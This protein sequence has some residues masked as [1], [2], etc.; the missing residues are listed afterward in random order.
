M[1]LLNN[2]A[3][4]VATIG[5]AASLGLGTLIPSLST[6]RVLATDTPAATA[7]MLA[8]GAALTGAG[9]ATADVDAAIAGLDADTEACSALAS[10]E[11]AL[12]SASETRRALEETAWREGATG[13]TATD[14]APARSA[15]ASA[16]AALESAEADARAVLMGVITSRLGSDSA[17]L[18]AR[19]IANAS[20]N[21]PPAYK[22]LDLD[23]AGFRTLESAVSKT[24]RG[25]TLTTAESTALSAAQSSQTVS[26]VQSRLNTNLA[27]I[28]SHVTD[29][30][31]AE[32][33]QQ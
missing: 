13:Q 23:D 5:I 30:I 18:A 12:Q 4:V 20:Y 25:L 3:S 7:L 9:C 29:L 33:S 1:S 26:T 11:A 6:A 17:T 2:R 31:E 8:P 27:T 21:V 10:A 24:A 32:L 14:L 15:E 22:A 19:M 28:E 16:R